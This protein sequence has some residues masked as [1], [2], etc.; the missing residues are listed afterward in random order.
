MEH[1]KYKNKTTCMHRNKS[2]QLFYMVK[3]ASSKDH[4]HSIAATFQLIGQ[5]R[6]VALH[7]SLILYIYVVVN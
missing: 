3:V 4:R 6:H 1:H 7:T 5:L 2:M